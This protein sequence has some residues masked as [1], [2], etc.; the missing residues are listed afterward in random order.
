[1]ALYIVVWS[2]ALCLVYPDDLEFCFETVV[3]ANTTT[4][5]CFLSVNSGDYS[6]GFGDS[7][8]RRLYQVNFLV[9]Y[10]KS[11]SPKWLRFCWSVV[12]WTAWLAWAQPFPCW[13]FKAE[14]ARDSW[15]IMAKGNRTSKHGTTPVTYHLV[16]TNSNSSPW[17]IITI[18]KNG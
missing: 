8:I 7:V 4:R 5:T 2:M 10:G 17:K 6:T 12:S 9:N 11:A 15:I 3:S 1:M 13:G 16:M 14:Q 18:F